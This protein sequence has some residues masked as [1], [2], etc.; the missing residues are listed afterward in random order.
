MRESWIWPSA[1]AVNTPKWLFFPL[2]AHPA[3]LS[4]APEK[5]YSSMIA[6][7]LAQTYDAARI[8][9]P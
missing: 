6:V 7:T 8:A 5:A 9:S 3:D 2:D 4:K 1:S